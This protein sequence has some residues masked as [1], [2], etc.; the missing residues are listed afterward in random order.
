MLKED[1]FNDEFQ[2]L[3]AFREIV[4]NLGGS[5]LVR[6]VTDNELYP[7][8]KIGD[9]LAFFPLDKMTIESFDGVCLIV[10]SEYENILIKNQGEF[11]YMNGNPYILESK[12]FEIYA[13]RTFCR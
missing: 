8:F 13:L 3:R 5:P 10:F 9:F 7:L 6:V 4:A 12:D 1:Y 11:T 2:R